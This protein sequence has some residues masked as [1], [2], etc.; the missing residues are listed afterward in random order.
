MRAYLLALV[1][2]LLLGALLMWL[3]QAG[4]GYVLVSLGQTAVEMSFWGAGILLLL[5]VVG[6]YCAIAL[7]GWLARMGGL[8]NWWRQ[9]RHSDRQQRSQVGL[10][11]YALGLWDMAAEQLQSASEVSSAASIQLLLAARAQ[12]QTGN[13]NSARAS[14]ERYKTVFPNAAVDADLILAEILIDEQKFA[15]AKAL[16]ATIKNSDAADPARLSALINAHIRCNQWVLAAALL[17]TLG[18]ARGVCKASLATL[19]L[20]VYRGQLSDFSALSGDA[21]SSSQLRR[22]RLDELWKRIPRGLKKRHQ[23]VAPYAACLDRLGA[24]AEAK[25]L[26]VKTLNAGWQPELVGL[27]G[28]IQQPTTDKHLACAENWLVAHPKD[29]HLLIALGQI[30]RRL[31]FFVKATDYLQRAHGLSPSPRVL[32]EL[33]AVK[34]D[35]GDAAGSARLYREGLLTALSSQSATLPNRSDTD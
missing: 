25:A 2:A 8:S 24:G 19:E 7:A 35:M 22:E 1:L 17:P 18:A 21:A 20:H 14:L 13:I 16:V 34:A 5:W 15:E 10:R 30:C 33:A 11:A 6:L 28:S 32:S 27:F 23:L 29:A 3:M 4:S 12:A 26:L 9:R 31:R